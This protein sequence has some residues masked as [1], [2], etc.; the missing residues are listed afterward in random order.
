MDSTADGAR[1]I[2]YRADGTECTGDCDVRC[3]KGGDELRRLMRRINEQ[4]MMVRA[5]RKF[6]GGFLL[7]VWGFNVLYCKMT[8]GTM[9]YGRIAVVWRRR[10]C[11][12]LLQ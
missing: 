12:L 7:G 10:W 1:S 6:V 8:Y 5:D 9:K 11:V 3:K 4:R 2:H